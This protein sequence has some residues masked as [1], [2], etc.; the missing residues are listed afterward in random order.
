MRRSLWYV[1]LVFSVVFLN[2]SCSRDGASKGARQSS[3]SVESTGLTND[4]G[5]PKRAEQA[6]AVKANG[7]ANATTVPP[8]LL[9][10]ELIEAGWISLFDG[11]SLF[12]WKP[13]GDAKWAVSDGVIAADGMAAGFLMTTF[14]LADYEFQCEF[15]LEAKGNS[16]I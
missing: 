6:P 7:D 3:D 15:R 12:G 5:T 1:I 10:R 14:Q 9:P 16:G 2:A 11:H 13:S 8:K 4:A